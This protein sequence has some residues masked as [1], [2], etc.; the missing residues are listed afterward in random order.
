MIYATDTPLWKI[1][2][3]VK[4]RVPSS[5]KG[6]IANVCLNAFG[7]TSLKGLLTQR[8]CSVFGKIK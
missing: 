5:S 4:R 2:N 8:L 3:R 7:T 6:R 1:A